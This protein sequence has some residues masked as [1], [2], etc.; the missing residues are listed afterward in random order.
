MQ[1]TLTEARAIV[2]SSPTDPGP[3]STVTFSLLFGDR[4]EDIPTC[5]HRQFDPGRYIAHRGDVPSKIFVVSKGIAMIGA[6][7]AGASEFAG[8]V[9]VHSEVVGLVE[10]LAAR[11]LTYDVVTSTRCEV[12]TITRS[13]LIQ[14]LATHPETRSRVIRLL[15][16]FVRD[17]DRLL[18]RL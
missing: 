14:H 5:E 12:R 17:A 15:A 13:S 1:S 4:G 10:M 7:D 9:L 6:S 3:L 8:R 11:P 18:K 2:H 16:E